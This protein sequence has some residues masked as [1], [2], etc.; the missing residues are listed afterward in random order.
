MEW[1]YLKM[2]DSQAAWVSKHTFWRYS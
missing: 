2:L 1:R